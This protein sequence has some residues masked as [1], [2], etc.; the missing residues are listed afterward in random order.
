MNINVFS[1]IEERILRPKPLGKP[2]T[3]LRGRERQAGNL[4]TGHGSSV[5]VVRLCIDSESS[6][7]QG[8]PARGNRSSE[9]IKI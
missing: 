9:E 5:L 3:G 2:D 4:I 6:A 1:D 8:N 7:G